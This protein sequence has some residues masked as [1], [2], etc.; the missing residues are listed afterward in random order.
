MSK[1][2]ATHLAPD[3]DGVTGIWLIK[4]YFPHWAEAEVKLVPAGTSL[5]NKNPDSDPDIIHVDTGGGRF[6]HHDN[7]ANTCAAALVFEYLKEHS[8]IP[9]KDVEPIS[10]IITYVVKI[11]HFEEIYFPEPTSDIYDFSMHQLIHGLRT[12]LHDT[13]EFVNHMIALLDAAFAGLRI[14]SYALRD[15]ENGMTLHTKLG[16]VLVMESKNEESVKLALKMGFDVA[17][18]KDPVLGFVK[19]KSHPGTGPDLEPLYNEFKKK[20]AI[21]TWFLHASHNIIINGSSMTPNATSTSLTLPNIV[22]I[23]RSMK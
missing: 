10:H 19:C 15:I 4:K 21:A 2:I 6:D 16:K 23:I 8:H 7:D 22:E 3:L 9:E 1:I 11:D 12:V 5:D 14:K 18:R 17:L 13:D 20:D